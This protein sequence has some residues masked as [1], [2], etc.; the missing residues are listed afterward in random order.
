V[1]ASQAS[2]TTWMLKDD[3]SPDEGVLLSLLRG[4]GASCWPALLLPCR[5]LKCMV[6]PVSLDALALAAV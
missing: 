1:D 2:A 4:H 5:R 6:L 3:A